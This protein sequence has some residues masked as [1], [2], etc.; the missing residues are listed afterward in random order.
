MGTLETHFK[1]Q[2]RGR[3]SV[4]TSAPDL[5]VSLQPQRTAPNYFPFIFRSFMGTLETHSGP[6][7]YLASF[8]VPN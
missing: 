7:A 5:E 8:G 4:A 2:C 3:T 1:V 6:G